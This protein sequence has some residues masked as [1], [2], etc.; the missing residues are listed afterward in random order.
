[1]SQN[2]RTGVYNVNYTLAVVPARG[3][4]HVTSK[5]GGTCNNP[6]NKPLDQTT[7]LENMSLS[8]GTVLD[9]EAQVDPENPNSL[10]GS[11]TVTT[12]MQRGGEFVTTVTWNL[13]YCQK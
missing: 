7:T 4:Y 6:F 13:L 12:P 10:V 1:M 11:K 8:T 5:V 9:I 3:T 2:N